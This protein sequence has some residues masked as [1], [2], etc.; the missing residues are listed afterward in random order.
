MGIELLMQN[1]KK[2]YAPGIE[3]GIKLKSVRKGTPGQLNFT[4]IND[5]LL[6]F[7]EGNP[8]RFLVDGKKLFYGYVFEKK[9]SGRDTIDVVC[10]DQLRYFKNKDTYIYKNKTASQVLKMVCSDFGLKAGKITDTKHVISKKLESNKT[11]F[12]IVQNALDETMQS[13]GKLYVLYDDFGRICLTD[14]AGM[15]LNL[16][17]CDETA[18]GFTYTSSIDKDVY[19][20]IKLAYTNQKTGKIET[21][22]AQDS[23]NINKWGVLQYYQSEQ[24]NAGLKSKTNSLLKLYNRKSRNLTIKNAAG[25][26]RV[27]AGCSLLVSLILDDIRI[28][29]YMLVDEVTHTFKENVHTMDVKLIGGDF[30]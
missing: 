23:K 17:I 16:L 7:T 9:R 12:D 13:K 3:E 5:G 30:V 6:K 18:E 2:I 10:Y 27:R 4:A 25:D 14:V 29:N 20:K 22:I 26:I 1:G 11:L 15:K 8:V 28:N 19:N 21:Y 24:N